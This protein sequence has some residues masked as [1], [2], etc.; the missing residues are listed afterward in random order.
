VSGFR[1][2]VDTMQ[3]EGLGSGKLVAIIGLLP[4]FLVPVIGQ[5]WFIP[6]GIFAAIWIG[7]LIWRTYWVARTGLI[8][9]AA[10]DVKKKLNG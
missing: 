3:T 8:G 4:M 6:S 7:Y 9:G 1:N 5:W 2:W 10:S